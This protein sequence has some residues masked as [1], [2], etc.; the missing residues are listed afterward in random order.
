MQNCGS[1]VENRVQGRFDLECCGL[2]IDNFLVRSFLRLG[3]R[4]LVGVKMF[5]A[6]L[7]FLH[8]QVLAI[9]ISEIYFVF[10]C[11]VIK[12]SS[13]SPYRPYTF[14]LACFVQQVVT[15]D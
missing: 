11:K 9:N 4:H 7:Y 12:L 2:T 13:I 10:N 14:F 3:K 15:R 5:P 6:H 8:A 1:S